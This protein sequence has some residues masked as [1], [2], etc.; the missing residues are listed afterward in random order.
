MDPSGDAAKQRE[1]QRDGELR[2]RGAVLFHGSTQ[3]LERAEF[4]GGAGSRYIS[5][6]RRTCSGAQT[7]DDEEPS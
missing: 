7:D 5:E 2:L 3:R 1:G 6:E 4:A